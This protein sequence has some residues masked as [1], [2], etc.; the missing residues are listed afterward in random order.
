ML[1]L[2]HKLV[3]GFMTGTNQ[4]YARQRF[5]ANPRSNSVH[6][7]HARKE[8][9]TDPN[10]GARLDKI[11][12]ENLNTSTQSFITSLKEWHDKNDFLTAGQLSAFEKVESR[13]SPGEKEKLNSWAQEYTANYTADAKLLAR[14]YIKA[15][16][17]TAMA[18]HIINDEE[19]IPPRHKYMKMSTNKYAQNVM[20]NARDLP[21]FVKGSMVQLRSTF[22]RDSIYGTHREFANRLC[23]VISTRA[24]TLSAVKGG[25]GYTILPMGHSSPISVEERHLMKP[26]KKGTSC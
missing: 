24:D 18:S 11:L 22:G 5:Y 1:R 19:Y 17:W 9:K 2:G 16:Y 20:S 23:F 12:K 15:G 3:G 7:H 25:K 10:L 8:K 13:Y 26:N 4:I 21:K 6:D 14:Y